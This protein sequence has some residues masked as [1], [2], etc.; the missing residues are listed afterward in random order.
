MT[1]EQIKSLSN[2]ELQA[3]ILAATI[4]GRYAAQRRVALAEHWRRVLSGVLLATGR[5]I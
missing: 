4:D 1:A 3:I 2:E 5:L